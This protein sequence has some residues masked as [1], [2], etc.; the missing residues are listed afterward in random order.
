MATEVKICGLSRREDIDACLAA[1][2]DL[3]G[4]VFFDKSPRA[5]AL[6]VA[7]ALAAPVRGRLG[8]VAL[9]VNATDDV[10]AAIAAD[11]APDFLQLHGSESPE[12]VAEIAAKFGLRTIKALPVGGAEDL[13]AAA[14]YAKVADRLLLDARPPRQATRPGGNGEPFDWELLAGFEP[15]LPWFLSGG[16]SPDNVGEA[17]RRTGAPGLDVSSGVESAPGV[18]DAGRIAAFLAAARAADKTLGR[19]A[20][21]PGDSAAPDPGPAP[22]G[23]AAA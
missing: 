17:L 11:L 21:E 14:S 9:T 23:F 6:D 13:R 8:V 16:L 2:A 18:K 22:R 20:G 3:V 12:R 4:F 19:K 7:A 10:V 15:G 5:L 1:G